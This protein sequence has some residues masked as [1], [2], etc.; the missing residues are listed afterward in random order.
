MKYDVV[1]AGAGPAGLSAGLAAASRGVSVLIVEQN[2]EIG[3][4]TRTSGGSFIRE[5]LALDIPASLLHPIRQIRFLSPNHSAVFRYEEPV[6]CVMDVRGVYQHLAAMA[7]QAGA[8]FWLGAKAVD[9]LRDNGRMTGIRVQTRAKAPVEVAAGVTIDAT[10][11]RGHLLR[12]AGVGERV[13]RFGVGAE[14][15][16][17]APQCDETE[18]VLVVGSRF[19]PSG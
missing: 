12:Q 11:Y 17:F 18:A 8:Q 1:I 14:F 4:P 7:A 13:Q 3:S 10:G 19:A 9:V 2:N 15:D 6:M 16:L 5:L